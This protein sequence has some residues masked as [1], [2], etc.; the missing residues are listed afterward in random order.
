[1]SSLLQAVNTGGQNSVAQ[2]PTQNSAWQELE[3]QLTGGNDMIFIRADLFNS[4]DLE[5]V[6]E[7]RATYE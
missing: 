7:I 5:Q 3:V 2:A 6:E 4:W 1:M